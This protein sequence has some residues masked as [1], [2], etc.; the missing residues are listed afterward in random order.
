MKYGSRNPVAQALT[1][2]WSG[3]GLSIGADDWPGVVTSGDGW[4]VIVTRDASRYRLQ[5]RSSAKGKRWEP[6]YGVPAAPLEWG[7][8][9]AH[10]CPGLGKA[11]ERLPVD[12][13]DAV[14]ALAASQGVVVPLAQRRSYWLDPDYLGVLATDAN[15]RSVR[16]RTGSLYSIQWISPADYEAGKPVRWIT[17]C[18]AASWPVLV[19]RVLIKTVSPGDAPQDRA[20]IRLRLVALFDGVPEL[21]A[22]GPWPVV[23]VGLPPERRKR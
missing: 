23:K 22:D 21:A 18:V 16:D 12:P 10:S 6:F 19:E 8:A 9:L 20:T 15:M 5:R 3:R 1:A 11:V 2:S 7:A 13:Q 17:Q 14:A 4:R